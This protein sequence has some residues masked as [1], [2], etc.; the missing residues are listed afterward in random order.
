M[1]SDR[2]MLAKDLQTGEA[3]IDDDSHLKS[4][5]SGECCVACAGGVI[6]SDALFCALAGRKDWLEESTDCHFDVARRIEETPHLVRF[7]FDD[8]VSIVNQE[9]P[10]LLDAI[11][12][13]TL[14]GDALLHE[15]GVLVAG[16]SG[17]KPLIVEWSS[18]NDFAASPKP[19]NRDGGILLR[20]PKKYGNEAAAR[21]RRKLTPQNGLPVE[22][23]ARNAVKYA[24]SLG[25]LVSPS[26]SLRLMSE[27]FALHEGSC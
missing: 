15:T 19:D 25:L 14:L 26:Y 1:V 16:R 8:A 20:W 2:R 21:F 13:N 23:R 10:K 9:L 7:S 3:E 24:S 5:A 12:R 17:G 6:L 4:I 22:L 11:P 27:G 18:E